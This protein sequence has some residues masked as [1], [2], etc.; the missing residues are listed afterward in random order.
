M[1]AEKVP[2]H[3]F[4]A[5]VD[6]RTVVVIP[7]GGSRTAFRSSRLTRRSSRRHRRI[8]EGAMLVAK[9]SFVAAYESKPVA[10]HRGRTRLAEGHELARRFPLRFEPV[11][12]REEAASRFRHLLVGIGTYDEYRARLDYLT[13]RLE[14]V[15]QRGEVR[16]CGE[17][18]VSGS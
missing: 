14:L 7:G 9:R 18:R 4:V 6:G 12:M 11:N 5:E 16:V 1:A 17:V 8:G 2:T 15:E 13:A 10:V 3:M